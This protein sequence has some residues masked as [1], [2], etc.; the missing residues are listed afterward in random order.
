[1]ALR[2]QAAKQLSPLLVFPHISA[3]STHA[4]LE[5]PAT[6]YGNLSEE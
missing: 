2:T 5:R 3:L 6:Y 1:M 4:G